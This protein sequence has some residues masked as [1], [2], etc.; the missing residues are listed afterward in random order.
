M[1]FLL[2][3]IFLH[4]F[5]PNLQE[6]LEQIQYK[7][8]TESSYIA[9]TIDLWESMADDSYISFTIHFTSDQFKRV[10]MKNQR[11]ILQK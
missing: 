3:N 10:N 2:A 6:I 9:C 11:R 4:H 7:I 5:A 1:E 8:N